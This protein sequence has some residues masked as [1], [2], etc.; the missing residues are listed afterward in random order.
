MGG[1]TKRFEVVL[2]REL[3]VLAIL[4]GGGK[5]LIPLEGRAQ[6]VVPCLE[7]WGGVQQV[8]DPLFSH[9]VALLPVI[10]DQP[11]ITPTLSIRCLM[12][13]KV[14]SQKGLH[15]KGEFIILA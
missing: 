4:M 6:K 9:F 15:H 1:D 11:L 8:L 14:S 5:G 2:T 13:R 7:R 12:N 3:E 10:N